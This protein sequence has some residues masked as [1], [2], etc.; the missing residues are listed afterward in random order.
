M[1]LRNL[2]QHVCGLVLTAIL[3]GLAAATLIRLA[4]GFDADEREFDPRLNEASIRSL[5]TERAADYNLGKFYLNYLAGLVR[6][7]FGISHS[8]RRPVSELLAERGPVTLELAGWGWMAGWALG[9][10]LAIAAAH[11]SAQGAAAPSQ[12][13]LTPP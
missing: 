3:G 7:N 1:W 8:F 4:P 9:L 5:R 13:S 12:R 2:G 6:G 10:G 11:C